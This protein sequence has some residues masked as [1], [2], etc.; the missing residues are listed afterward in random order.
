M[1]EKAN[2]FARFFKLVRCSKRSLNHQGS[3]RF[4]QLSKNLIPRSLIVLFFSAFAL[5]FVCS[6]SQPLFSISWNQSDS[7][8]VR[9]DERLSAFSS[10]SYPVEI[11]RLRGHHITWTVPEQLSIDR[12]KQLLLERNRNTSSPS[13]YLH[14]L[15]TNGVDCSY[16]EFVNSSCNELLEPFTNGEMAIR[17]F[18][19]PILFRSPH[20]AR[21][22]TKIQ[23]YTN[24]SDL[25]EVHRDQTLAT[26]AELGMPL[27]YSLVLE[28]K[29]RA[30]FREILADSVAN[31]HLGQRELEWT[32]IAYALLLPPQRTW[33]NKFS[34]QY[35]FDQL[36]VELIR[37]KMSD[38]CC[39]GTHRLMALT[40]LLRINEIETILST[41]VQERVQ[42]Y[43]DSYL[44]LVIQSQMPQGCW[45]GVPNLEAESS[46]QEAGSSLVEERVLFT[47]HLAEWLLYVPESFHVPNSVIDRAA[48]WLSTKINGVP[49][50]KLYAN[51]CPYSHALI[52][53]SSS[54][55]NSG[56]MSHTKR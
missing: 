3:S 12:G 49:E 28:D 33:R 13:L 7:G 50:E 1:K 51:F 36:A 52:V 42:Q 6:K 46:N 54:E 30:C 40:F 21:F 47:G 44:T 19:Q 53:L 37:R 4:L 29:D 24:S 17:Q 56:N 48:V 23:G 22:P 43:I 25:H 16:T 9:K 45:A 5:Y 2:N 38:A 8:T 20:G 10:R 15:R 39:G 32:C 18:G 31:F 35:N 55:Q 11:H 41:E 14:L 34:E 26:L 27:D